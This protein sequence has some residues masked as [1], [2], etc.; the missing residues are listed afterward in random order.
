[1]FG[2]VT[3]TR[4]IGKNNFMRVRKISKGDCLTWSC[5]SVRMKQ[6]RSLWTDFC[7]ILY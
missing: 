5:P 1:M 3:V 7:E 6:F 2:C 4:K